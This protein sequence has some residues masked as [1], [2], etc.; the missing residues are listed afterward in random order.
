MVYDG[1]SVKGYLN[2][3][4]QG[5]QTNARIIPTSGQFYAIGA[6]GDQNLGTNAYGK[7]NLAQ[8]KIYNLPFTI[9]QPLPLPL[10]G[11]YIPDFSIVPLDLIIF[12]KDKKLVI[13]TDDLTEYILSNI[14]RFSQKFRVVINIKAYNIRNI[15]FK[16]KY[17]SNLMP[18]SH[19]ISEIYKKL[20][21]FNGKFVE[22]D[23]FELIPNRLDLKVI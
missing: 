3:I 6:G 17:E 16:S 14:I 7:F 18:E 2:G 9:K 10:Y 5:T 8:F 15:D 13:L 4:L 23:S 21:K 1:A 22:R 19:E 11:D 12:E 20:L